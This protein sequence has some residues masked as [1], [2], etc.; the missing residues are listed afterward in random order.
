MA[1]LCSKKQVSARR[2]A[3]ALHIFLLFVRSQPKFLR[4]N[5]RYQKHGSQSKIKTYILAH[6]TQGKKRRADYS[7]S[8]KKLIQKYELVV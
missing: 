1:Q 8:F 4:L 6:D 3:N 7:F 5:G 2:S